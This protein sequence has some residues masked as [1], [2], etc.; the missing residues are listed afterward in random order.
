VPHTG[1]WQDLGVFASYVHP[2][3][4]QPHGLRAVN[5]VLDAATGVGRSHAL[6]LSHALAI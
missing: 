3:L 5:V 4:W 2:Q 1:S 6:I